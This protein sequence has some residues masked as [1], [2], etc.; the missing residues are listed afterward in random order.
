[1]ATTVAIYRL[2]VDDDMENCVQFKHRSIDHVLH[3]PPTHSL[4]PDSQKI[5]GSS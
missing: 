3:G 4:G 2:C 5:L 1:M